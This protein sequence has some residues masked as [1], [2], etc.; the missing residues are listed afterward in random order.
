MIV[1][2]L[3]LALAVQ[4]P[5]PADP[6]PAPPT[7]PPAADMPAPA[8]PESFVTIVREARAKLDAGDF[9][10]AA[11]RYAEA[12]RARPEASAAAYNQGV[13]LYRDGKYA[14]AARAFAQAAE[15]A[16]EGKKTDAAVEA[17]ST[18]N[19]AASHY[20]ATQAQAEAAERMLKSAAVLDRQAGDAATKEPVDP[21]ALKAAIED[22]QKSLQGFKDAALNDPSDRDARANAQQSLRLL[23][24][25]EELKK[26]QEQQQQQQQQNEQQE[27]QKQDQRQQDQQ[28]QQQKQQQDDQQKQEQKGQGQ[29]DQDQPQQPSPTEGD[30]PPP[31]EPAEQPPPP[32]PSGERPGEM[33]KQEADRLL[34]AVR[35]RERERRADQERA[36]AA[37]KN[38]RPPAKDW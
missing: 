15:I 37:P 5:P 17:R 31:E 24:A 6:I 14:D 25:L 20:R 23:R 38:R 19:K 11:E 8:S 32:K 9:A 36:T 29:Q 28:Q 12:L 1:G 2:P 3:V 21:E 26:Q 30:Q 18:Y 16:S 33:T 27:Q 7:P 22:A 4:A 34:Q 35:D 13:A 10:A